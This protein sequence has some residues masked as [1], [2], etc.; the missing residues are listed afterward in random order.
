MEL[1]NTTFK[2]AVEQAISNM[3]SSLF[4]SSNLGWDSNVWNFTNVN[5]TNKVYPT[6]KQN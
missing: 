1:R 5:L 6:L 3:S 2:Y 4:Y